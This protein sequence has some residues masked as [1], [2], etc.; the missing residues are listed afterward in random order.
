MASIVSE[1]EGAMEILGEVQVDTSTIGEMVAENGN[2]KKI[3][4][5]PMTTNRNI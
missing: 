4:A 5:S 1:F 2:V 3:Q